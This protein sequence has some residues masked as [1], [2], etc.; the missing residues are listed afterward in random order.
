[1]KTIIAGTDFTAASV[2]ACH[3]AAFLAQKLH[4]KLT[5]FNLFDAPII[6]SNA[7]LYGISYSAQKSTSHQRSEKLVKQLQ[8]QFPK[9]KIESFITIGSFKLELENF[10]ASHQI[11]AAVMGLEAKTRFSK[12][13]YGS[14]GVDIAGKIDCPVIIVPSRYKKHKLSKML[15]TVDNR[16]KLLRSS[17]KELE[18]FVKQSATKLSLLHVRTQNEI[19][20]PVMGDVK[21]NGKKLPIDVLKAK[22][23]QDGVRKYCNAND[24][25]MVSIISKKHSVFYNLFVESNT[26]KVAFVA[27][28]PVMSLHI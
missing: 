7:G 10:V 19:F 22:D 1:M 3:Y 20:D 17:L 24:I 25:D 23:I 28:V 8:L 26:K 11:E 21:I 13:I 6:H 16:E 5:I 2:N 27:K 12:F 9:L 18:Q 14:H 4:C 15:L